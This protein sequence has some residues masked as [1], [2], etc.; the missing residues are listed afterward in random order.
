MK[1][2]REYIS[3]KM[4]LPKD[5]VMNLPRVSICGDRE[6]YIENHKGLLGYTDSC[7]SI[8]MDDGIMKVSGT[9]LR[10]IVMQGDRLVMNGDF[11]GVDYEKFGRKRKNVQKNL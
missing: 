6:I 2:F 7:I 9:G 10:I 5:V 3:D 8:K 4:N 1:G 11:S